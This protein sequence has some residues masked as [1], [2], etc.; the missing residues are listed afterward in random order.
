V[1]E[2]GAEVAERRG[3]LVGPLRVS[4]PVSFG[5]LHLSPALN[6]FLKRNPRIE[7]SLEL[8]DRF[9][10]PTD[11]FDVIIRHGALPY[12]GWRAKPIAPSRRLLV[13]SPDYLK[14]TGHPGP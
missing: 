5:L 12:K 6:S 11:G 8:N 14:A 3:A 10:G 7:L 2:A 13:A 4:V 1:S 9:V